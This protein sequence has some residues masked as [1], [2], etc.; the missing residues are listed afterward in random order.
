VIA[1]FCPRPTLGAWRELVGFS[2]WAWMLQVVRLAKGRVHVFVLGRVVGT[3]SVGTFSIAI[4]IASLP[5]TELLMPMGRALFSAILETRR[6][7]G[8]PETIWL[9]VVGL[10]SIIAFPAGIGLALVAEPL[11]RLMLGPQWMM[12]VPLIQ[13]AAAA[14]TFSVFEHCCHIQLDSS[15]LIHVD[16][17]AICITAVVRTALALALVP[18][19]GL[20]GAVW[21]VAIA[22]VLDQ[23]TYLTIKKLVLSLQFSLLLRQV[24][25]PALATSVMAVSVAWSGLAR[26]PDGADGLSAAMHLTTAALLGVVLYVGM[27]LLTWQFSGRPDGTE[28]DILVNLRQRLAR[29]MTAAR[30][31]F[32]A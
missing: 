7:G 9:R 10:I 28:A 24:W 22:T 18:P 4:E 12:A 20:P 6:T 32:W 15:G 1:P 3:A 31:L 14:G 27:I 19:F 13:I 5:V 21:G 8:D 17:Q 23:I 29:L 11:V 2:F 25:R 30:T 16:F 26:L